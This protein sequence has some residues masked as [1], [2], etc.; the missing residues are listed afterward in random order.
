MDSWN[1]HLAGMVGGRRAWC[2]V[3]CPPRE[4]AGSVAWVHT[5]L[6]F[7][8]LDS[9]GVRRGPASAVLCSVTSVPSLAAGTQRAP[10]TLIV[11]KDTETYNL[12]AEMLQLLVWGT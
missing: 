2:L 11:L 3:I 10:A 6:Y 1:V 12:V 7:S 5:T 4:A 9:P 8:C